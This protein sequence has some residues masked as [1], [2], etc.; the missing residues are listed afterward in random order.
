[1]VRAGTLHTI[2]Q[3]LESDMAQEGCRGGKRPRRAAAVGGPAK[4]T[5]L[6][7]RW[8]EPSV[9]E[10]MQKL[11]ASRAAAE[12]E[13]A[14]ASG[15]QGAAAVPAAGGMEAA[16]GAAAADAPESMDCNGQ[17]Q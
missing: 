2:Q 1:M 7:L 15:E 6:M 8:K 10:R 12:A 9:E 3:R 5:P 13:A 17:G 4:H 11:E 16:P 14:A